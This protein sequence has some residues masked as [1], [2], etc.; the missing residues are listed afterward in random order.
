MM[1]LKNSSFS[2]R[3]P[4]S[5]EPEDTVFSLNAGGSELFSIKPDGQI[6]RGP[7]FTT[8]DEMS[9]MFWKMLAETYPRFLEQENSK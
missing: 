3:V 7:A 5:A 9:L 8:T 1:D 4:S 2:V 6:V